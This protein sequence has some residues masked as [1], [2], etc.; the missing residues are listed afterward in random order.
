MHC[1]DHF[2]GSIYLKQLV[3][4]EIWKVI[5]LRHYKDSQKY[6]TIFLEY[7]WLSEGYT[8]LRIQIVNQVFRSFW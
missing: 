2:E 6:K 1:C 7:F 5:Q 8:Y 4:H 3:L